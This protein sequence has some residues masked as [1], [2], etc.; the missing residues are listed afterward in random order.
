[1]IQY[2]CDRC[3]QV[4]KD[5][6]RVEVRDVFPHNGDLTWSDADICTKCLRKAKSIQVRFEEDV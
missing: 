3:N 4:V 1:M 5:A 2:I 6:I